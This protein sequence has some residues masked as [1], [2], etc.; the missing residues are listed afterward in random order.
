[1]ALPPVLRTLRNEH[2][3]KY[4]ASLTG[5]TPGT[6]YTS[7][8]GIWFLPLTVMNHEKEVYQGVKGAMEVRICTGELLRDPVI[9][10]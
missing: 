3:N 10:R 6:C 8:H 4:H 9:E 2:H 7:R 5:V 1:M